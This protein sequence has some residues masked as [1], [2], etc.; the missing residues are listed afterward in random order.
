MG[1]STDLG[2]ASDPADLSRPLYGAS[3][4]TAVK[5]FFKKYAVFTGRA[6][7]S[8]YWWPSLFGF[9]VQLI[10][11]GLAVIGAV[12]SATWAAQNPIRTS[13]GF[14]ANGNEVFSETSPGLVHAPSAGVMFAG[15]GLSLVIGLA[16]LVPALALLWRRLHDANLAGLWA[17]L[18]LVPYVGGPI[19]I[20]LALL[21]SKPEGRRFDPQ[22]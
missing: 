11:S 14:D 1:L 2:G 19:V 8:E 12:N 9:L 7:R 20:V 21:P 13:M 22:P 6:S 5:R 4:G 16:L 17:L 3:F 18:E 10:P 15:V